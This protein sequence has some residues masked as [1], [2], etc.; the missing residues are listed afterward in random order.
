MDAA[1]N[2]LFS[3]KNH[4]IIFCR[5]LQLF[6]HNICAPLCSHIA[7]EGITKVKIGLFLPFLG[8]HPLRALIQVYG[9]PHIRVI[10]IV[11]TS[12]VNGI[13]A[14]QKLFENTAATD[15]MPTVTAVNTA[16]A[17]FASR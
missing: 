17:C 14:G 3:H 13:A 10:R 2:L 5:M 6:L 4:L 16:A 7:A 12:Q 11:D 8:Q 9:K 1:A 15:K